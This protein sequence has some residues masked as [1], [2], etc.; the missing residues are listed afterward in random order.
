[1]DPID[2]DW[3]LTQA[4][5]GDP[6]LSGYVP[7][8]G[9]HIHCYRPSDGETHCGIVDENRAGLFITCCNGRRIVLT[10]ANWA[11]QPTDPCTPTP[12]P[13]DPGSGT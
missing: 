4:F 5:P 2:L 12:A 3:C 9:Q 7:P 8:V 1:M 10:A 6:T 13:S 11:V